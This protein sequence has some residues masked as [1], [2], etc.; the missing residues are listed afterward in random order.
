M[1]NLTLTWLIKVTQEKNL[2]SGMWKT[3]N[4]YR[5]CQSKILKSLSYGYL[6]FVNF[7]VSCKEWSKV[8]P[9]KCFTDG[10]ITDAVNF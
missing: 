6:Y 9:L 5:V 1:F 10:L 2:Y 3:P 7:G 8:Y 4:I